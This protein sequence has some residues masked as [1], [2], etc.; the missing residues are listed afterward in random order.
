MTI[1]GRTGTAVIAAVAAMTSAA[2]AQAQTAHKDPWTQ[3]PALVTACLANDD[4]QDRLAAAS[5]AIRAEIETLSRLNAAAKEKFDS[6]DM[7]E[8]ARRM[9][10][11]ATKNPQAAMKMMQAQEAAGLAATSAVPEADANAQRLTEELERLHVEFAATLANA[12]QPVRAKQDALIKAKATL[13]DHEGAW[14]TSPADHAQ[15]VQLIDEENATIVQACAGY[16]GAG[17]AFHGW[18]AGWRTDV[19]EKLIAAGASQDL[20]AMQLELLGLQDEYRPT[21][22]HSEVLNYVQKVRDVYALRPARVNPTV[23]LRR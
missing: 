1:I 12:V 21:T 3:V 10:Q 18:L 4:F 5:T 23:P 22:A 8:Q 17:G 7:M 9:Q 20:V 14:F 15:Y 13:G 2:D 19:S 6:M 11:F 16:F